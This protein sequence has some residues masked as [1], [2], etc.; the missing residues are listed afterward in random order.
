MGDIV[1]LGETV[2]TAGAIYYYSASGDWVL[3]DANATSTSTGLLGVALGDSSA[4][5]GMLLR[6]MV[7]L[8]TDPGNISLPIYLSETAGKATTTAPTTSGA[9]VRVLG[10][11]V[12]TTDTQIWFNP[13]NTWV[14]LA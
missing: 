11:S 7:A 12:A 10:Y 4:E 14:E 5:T 9:V 6:G 1:Y 8:N 13:D 3:T 2:T